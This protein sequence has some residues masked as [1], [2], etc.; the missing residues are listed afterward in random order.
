MKSCPNSASTNVDYNQNTDAENFAE[1]KTNLNQEKQKTQNKR[2]GKEE[3]ETR[4]N[5]RLE[6]GDITNQKCEA[7]GAG[8][9]PSENEEITKTIM[10]ANKM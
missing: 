2:K 9:L 5:N 6:R 3:I 4:E 8:Q 1:G 7:V 10:A